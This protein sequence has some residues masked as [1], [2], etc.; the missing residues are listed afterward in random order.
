MSAWPGKYVIGLTGNIATGKSVI[1]KM[2]EHLG[3]YG[4]DAD[5]LGHRAIARDA[6]GYRPVLE[7]FG[8]WVLGDDDQIDRLKLAR[9]VFSDPQALT[10]LEAIVHPLVR[11]AVDMLIRRS[12]QQVIVLEAIKLLESP[13]RQGCDSIWVAYAPP[14]IQLARLM[15]KRGFTEEIARQRI[16]AQSAQEEK[17]TAANI[18]IRNDSS[19]EETWRQVLTAWKQQLPAV[20]PDTSPLPSRKVTPDQLVVEK[21]RPRQAAEIAELITRISGNTRKLSQADV[22]AAFGEK[23]FFLLL[24]RDKPVGVVGCQVENLVARTDDVYLDGNLSLEAS[25]R[26]LLEEVERTSRDLQCEASLLF[27]PSNLA[28]H[29]QV[30]QTL[31]YE[32]RSI[33]NLG[34]RAWQEAA[35]ESL[36]SGEELFFKQLRKDRVLRPV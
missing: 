1:R 29:K 14:E 30:W 11:Q 36:A 8:R 15:Q 21:A 24:V 20:T 25:M 18:I 31:G 16:T 22:M 3:A 34:V 5:A 32:P 7:M 12:T 27:L 35:Q 6:P 9:V 26:V 2:L 23:A 17:L 4:I 19:F 10:Q 13:L 33:Q 28:G